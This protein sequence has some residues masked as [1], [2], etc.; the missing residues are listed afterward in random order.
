MSRKKQSNPK[1]KQG[2]N[3]SVSNLIDILVTILQ[4]QALSNE[5]A[6]S[7]GRFYTYNVPKK[8]YRYRPEHQREIETV[9]T[10]KIWFS[11]ISSLNDP[12]ELNFQVDAMRIINSDIDMS[13]KMHSLPYLQQQSLLKKVSESVDY[14]E[15]HRNVS[16]KFTIACF[17]EKN[18]SLLMWGHYSSGHRGICI[19]Y[20]TID[21]G[22]AYGKVVV[23]VEYSNRLPAISLIDDTR[24][25]RSFLDIIRIKSSDWKYEHEWRCI[26]DTGA[27]G[28]NLTNNGALL[29]SSSPTAIY[30]GCMADGEFIKSLI[31]SCKETLQIPIYRM[32]KARNEF[33]LIPEQII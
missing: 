33:K 22:Q 13:K 31:S 32:V 4:G 1:Q 15:F 24:I 14:D 8:M 9:I 25:M 20:D 28:D 2:Q 3:F 17:S 18:D 19:E 5:D 11:K 7:I 29:D 30:L 23:P 21:L 10:N 27:C 26:Q 16:S 12:F 6:D